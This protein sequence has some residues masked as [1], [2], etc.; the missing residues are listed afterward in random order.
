MD[1][2]M[3][4]TTRDLADL[5]EATGVEIR[6]DRLQNRLGGLWFVPLGQDIAIEVPT[7]GDALTD[8]RLYGQ[9]TGVNVWTAESCPH[10]VYDEEAADDAKVLATYDPDIDRLV[11]E[12]PEDEVTERARRYLGFRPLVQWVGDLSVT[13]YYDLGVVIVRDDA[14]SWWAADL[15]EYDR[16]SRVMRY[17]PTSRH[18]FGSLEALAYTELC[19]RVPPLDPSDERVREACRRYGIRPETLDY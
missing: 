3:R 16:E 9:G 7:T 15:E 17:F 5:P 11:L 12:V 6:Q 14:P 4:P 10:A 1:T 8:C 13:P 2:A 18:D 19:Q